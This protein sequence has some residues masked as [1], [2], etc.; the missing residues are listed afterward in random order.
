MSGQ[1][2]LPSADETLHTV[3]VFG[4]GR[5]AHVVHPVARVLLGASK[6][7]KHGAGARHLA[8]VA[9]PNAAVAWGGLSCAHFYGVQLLHSA[10]ADLAAAIEGQGALK[11]DFAM[12]WHIINGLDLVRCTEGRLRRRLQAARARQVLPSDTGASDHAD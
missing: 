6:A 1:S 8:R 3:R 9:E 10:V 12:A 4:A 2:I 11:G 7:A 5:H